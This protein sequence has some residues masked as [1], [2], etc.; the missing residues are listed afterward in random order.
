MAN[1]DLNDD[2]L[3]VIVG[4]GAGGGTLGN[5]LAQKGVKVVILEA[6]SRY[7]IQDFVNDEWE[8]FAQLAWTDMRTTT[9][10]WRV[11]RDFPNLPAWIVKAVGGTTTH[12]AGASLRFQD[13]EF[14][15]R[16][17]YGKV[18]GANLLDWPI[19]LD[20]LA[21]WYDEAEIAMGSTHRHGR[22]PQPANNNYRVFA[23]GAERAGYRYYATGPYATNAEPYDGRPA[24]IQDGFNFQGDKHRSQW[25]TRVREIP[26]AIASGNCDLRPNSQAVKITHDDAGLVDGVEYVDAD[27][28]KVP[29]WLI[30]DGADASAEAVLGLAAYSAAAPA[31]VAARSALA[32]LAERQRLTGMIVELDVDDL[33]SL[34]TG[35]ATTLYGI[36]V[37][38]VRNVVRHAGATAC[39]I[40]AVHGPDG[41]VRLSIADDGVG[42]D[43]D[44]RSGV[45]R[46]GHVGHL[47]GGRSWGGAARLLDHHDRVPALLVRLVR[48]PPVRRVT[49]DE[50]ADPPELFGEDAGRHGTVA[51]AV[52]G[53]GERGCGVEDDEHGG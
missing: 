33:P 51:G 24:S 11:A 34:S 44:A 36:V 29:A 49:F 25:S 47:F 17:T 12:W 35:V 19:T 40:S 16:T 45:G 4:S 3:V 31:D 50:R 8:S 1:F 41:R 15:A 10:S 13:Y 22:P 9:G 14:K 2:S 46:A 42:V 30:V 6:G 37:E 38:A 20:E 18:D 28:T 52:P 23:N 26:R 53:P 32:E 5:E 39:R 7:E 48:G 43:P 21:P 27:G